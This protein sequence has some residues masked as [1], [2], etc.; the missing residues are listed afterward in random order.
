[1]YVTLENELET[2]ARKTVLF[3]ANYIFKKQRV[4]VNI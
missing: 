3:R 1:M 4:K 2:C